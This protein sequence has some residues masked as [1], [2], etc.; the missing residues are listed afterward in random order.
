MS[1]V[2]R[3]RILQKEPVVAEFTQKKLAGLFALASLLSEN[4]N[5]GKASEEDV[6]RRVVLTKRKKLAAWYPDAYHS[7]RLAGVEIDVCSPSL[8]CG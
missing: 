3:R 2:F 6:C 4:H 5:P 1:S 7:E 8:G